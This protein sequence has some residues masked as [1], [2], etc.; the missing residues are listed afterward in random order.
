[1]DEA[2]DIK[3]SLA[4]LFK[5]ADE[6]GLWFY[7]SYQ[8]LWFSPDDLRS[9]QANGRFVWGAVNWRLRRPSERM[10][11]LQEA[12]ISAKLAADRFRAQLGK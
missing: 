6:K 8:D 5:E 9:E 7:C 12:A 4:P 3:K 1:M 11:Q 2:T 10:D